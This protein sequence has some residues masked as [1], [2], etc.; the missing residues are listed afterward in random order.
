MQDKETKIIV[1]CMGVLFLVG[2]TTYYIVLND[3]QMKQRKRARASQK[4]AFHLLQQIKRDQEKIEK[5]I[6]N[7]IDIENDHHNV[8]KIEYTLAQCNELLLQLLERIDAIRPKDAIITA[9]QEDMD[10]IERI[11]TP[12]ETELIQQIKDRKR[13]IIQSIQRDFDRVDQC[14]QQ[15]LHISSSSSSSSS[16]V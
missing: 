2:A 13:R 14:K 5:D 16:I 6:L 8:K 12:F 9:V 4:Q 1:S 11:A 3:R 7:T 10:D 15:L